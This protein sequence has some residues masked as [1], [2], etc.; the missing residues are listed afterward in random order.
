LKPVIM[1]W[2]MKKSLTSVP[3]LVGGG[4][5]LFNAAVM[6]SVGIAQTKQDERRPAITPSQVIS[7][8]DFGEFG[9]PFGLTLKTI[10][11]C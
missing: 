11:L 6:N 3:L 7:G 2:P 9:P 8:L 5:R 10:F 4:W 1:T